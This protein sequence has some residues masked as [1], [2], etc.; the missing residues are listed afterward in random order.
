M[1]NDGKSQDLKG[2]ESGGGGGG[3]ESLTGFPERC[4]ILHLPYNYG[5]SLTGGQGEESTT[6]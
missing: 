4:K 5:L 1:V 2:A 3:G 6:L